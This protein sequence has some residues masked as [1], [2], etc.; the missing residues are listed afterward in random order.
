[1]AVD[2]YP[3]PPQITPGTH[4]PAA[5]NS[6]GGP[7]RYAH[8]LAGIRAAGEGLADIDLRELAR[9]IW[10]RKGTLVG[11]TVIGTVMAALV[12]FQLTP[13]YTSMAT[14]MID[15]RENQV[16]D[17][18]SVLSGLPA[19]QET[20]ESEIEVLLSR[21]LAE[22]VIRKLALYRSPEFNARLRP[23]SGAQKIMRRLNPKSLVPDSVLEWLS[24]S[25]AG[26][27]L[28]EEQLL[29]KERIGIID[30]HLDKLDVKRV[31]RSRVISISVTLANPALAASVANAVADLYIV[32][33]LE[34]KFEATRRATEWLNERL[35]G[36]RGAVQK[37][38]QAVERYRRTSGL[39]EGKGV[40]FASQQATELN[41]Q[42]ILSRSKRAEA[43]ARLTQVERLV[44]NS[45]SV[46]SVAEVLASPLIQ[47]LRGQEADIQRKAAELSQ[48][49]GE[50][51]PRM[52][53]I[54]AEVVDLRRKIGAEVNKIVQGLRNEVA[55]ARAREN[56]LAGNMRGL[57]SRVAGLNQRQVQLRALEREAMANR[58]LYETFLNRF[59]ETNEQQEFQRPDAR[60][61]SSADTPNAPSAPKLKL[62]LVIA[63]TLSAGAGLALVFIL[64]SLDKGFRSMDDIEAGTG[65]PAIGLVPT[66][67]GLAAMGKEPQA[68]I[69]EKPNS[70][71]AESVRALHASILLSNVDKPPQ[72]VLMTSSLPS[73]GKTSLA[74][75]LARLVARTGSKRVIILDGDLRRPMVHRHLGM[76]IGPGLVQLMAEEASLEDTLRRDE[77]SGAYVLTAGGTPANPTDII[78]SD[79]FAQLLNSLKTTFDLI[80]IDSSP[81]LAVSD[82]RI[83]SRMADKTIFA[84][85]WAETR[86]EV[87]RLGLKQILEAGG[88]LAG[89]VLSM[90]NVKKHAR[91]G[92]SD[93]GYYHG[94][95]RKYYTD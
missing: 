62:L 56:E 73:E 7:I 22:R 42:L 41:S 84:V 72:T 83:L 47:Q 64:E 44:G 77:A 75:S 13:K 5:G 82:S 1:M 53:N 6:A 90:V 21:R 66:L 29:E 9:K 85:R 8:R 79:H 86:R 35:A 59:K 2:R 87:V 40:T 32:E 16:L 38:E 4:A 68:L 28:I 27:G 24:L 26:P 30:T 18:Q 89:V 49:Y 33:Q 15:P 36:L 46:D 51:H 67:S 69:L 25:S 61:I 91:Y 43:E 94:R 12:L 20:I 93:S 23:A 70:A 57:E 80:V 71:F 81:V 58:T 48:E 39:V 78:T 63:F 45:S 11:V 74:L 14:V 95:Y 92:Y 54:R 55:V 88:D 19:D 52:I 34:A 60:I 65:V 37:S 17:V 10:R 76:D 31:G 3:D 50:K